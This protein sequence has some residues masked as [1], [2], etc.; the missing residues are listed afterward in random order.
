MGV[1]SAAAQKQTED[2]QGKERLGGA[3]AD[4]V[5][6]LGRR[7]AEIAATLELLRADPSSARH[8]DDLRRRIHALGAGAR[9]LRFT[10][11]SEELRRLEDRLADAAD[12]GRL[13]D[14]DLDA[15]LELLTRVTSLAWGQS[16]TKAGAT[17]LT[18]AGTSVADLRKAGT[19]VAEPA[20]MPISVLVVGPS[21]F[22][23]ALAMPADGGAQPRQ[24]F[25]IE[26]TG[27]V[28]V[29]VDMAKAL[30]PDLVLVDGDLKG[31]VGLVEALSAESL[32]EQ[33]PVIV[34]ARFS[35][36]E[37]ASKFVALGVARTLPKPASP[38][39]LRRACSTVLASYV[40]R[41]IVR[42]ALGQV[43]ID[44]LG[45]RLAEE[46]RRG[47]CDAADLKARGGTVDLGEGT[48]VLAA[49]WGAVARIRDIVTIKSHGALRFAAGGP[50]GAMPLAPWLGSV[51]NG[52]PTGR[53]PWPRSVRSTSEVSLEKTTVVVA[54]DDPAVNWFLA[55]VL[56]AAGASVYEAR[57]GERAFEIAKHAEPDLVISDILMPKL[58]GFAL[59]R[60]L[61]RDVVLRDVPVVLLSWKEDLLQRVRELGADADGYLRKE[62]S[63]GAIV[64]RVKELLR[65]RRR[66]ADRI[67]EGGE[68][69]GRLDGLTTATLLRLAC[70]HRPSSTLSVRDASYL[71]EIEVRD[72][73]PVRATRTSPGGGFD[74]GPSV[75]AALLGAG[76][77]RFVVAPTREDD[78]VGK[79]RGDL[80]GTLSEQ[81]M[82][83]VAS[84]RAAQRLLVGASLVR[85]QRVSV[86][87]ERLEAYLAAT[88]EPARSVLRAIAEGASPRRLITSGEVSPRL[89]E[90]VLGDAAIHGAIC[91]IIDAQ[92]FDRLPE[93]T[94]HEI[95]LL[96]GE[97]AAQPIS[98]IPVLAVPALTP[99]PAAAVEV[100]MPGGQELLR[101]ALAV[102]PP[103]SAPASSAL[104]YDPS[105]RP[106]M[107]PA[108]A[109]SVASE[110]PV[111]E[112]APM[113]Q[114]EVVAEIA[115]ATMAAQ[116]TLDDPWFDAPAPEDESPPAPSGPRAVT[117]LPRNVRTPSPRP[118]VRDEIVERTP[119]PSELPPPPGLVPILTLG[120]LHPPPV[121]PEPEPEVEIAKSKK[122][123]SPKPA[124]VV[125]KK[126]RSEALREITP[127]APSADR[128][129][130]L[131]PSAYL[132][133]PPQAQTKKDRKALYWV[134]FALCGVSFALWARW[135]REKSVVSED[136]LQPA[137]AQAAPPAT[138]EA[139]ASP[140][141]TGAPAV[142]PDDKAS[143]N[144]DGS[145]VAPEDLPLRDSDKDR[146]KK[147]QG[148][149]EIVAGKSDTVYIDGK[150]M[151]SGPVISAPL[152]AKSDPYEV[153]V[154][155]RGEER[156][157]F[158]NV[159][160][161]RLTR[162]RVAPPWSR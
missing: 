159:K 117:P 95:M 115:A 25:E 131:L 98:S 146:V 97:R 140:A 65:Q 104:P 19:D 99:F 120:S 61:K 42:E 86:D 141:A 106:D 150:A 145:E 152:K 154:K 35:R 52:T 14:D 100:S 30:A 84:A 54:D 82:P 118:V 59:C 48:E 33:I 7:R 83:V 60:A 81:L 135:S 44:Q 136:V 147:G 12:R 114:D 26:E 8:R 162:V 32:T 96:R 39:E 68:V 13:D 27:E 148:L 73:R 139:T 134:L 24:V 76:D 91:E 113:P 43:S 63:A 88:P 124:E 49:L 130:I 78:E 127:I 66:V 3:R 93:G 10:A 160:E 72:G 77:G 109:S 71:Y 9:L 153:K 16:G 36:P 151:G 50:E 64:Q 133:H 89:L 144:K 46:L 105:A 69:R 92:G 45:A 38:G 122:S 55:G 79:V 56:K 101:A 62:A 126:E 22:G 158:V 34:V 119:T 58:D 70:K 125:A 21:S 156:V 51:E 75:L 57:D 74:R 123:K 23:A 155:L 128:R 143:T 103:T 149:L 11:L 137:S 112:P 157:R 116:P 40:H 110:A 132:P 17:A 111:L 129:P 53:S 80:V 5:A 90:D 4:F 29:A 18:A 138:A 85:V 15:V 2:G 87:E 107:Q 161:G 94:A 142:A 6:N 28:D 108:F 47:L 20:P 67:A 37:E 121:L 1:A 102:R 41:E 31:S